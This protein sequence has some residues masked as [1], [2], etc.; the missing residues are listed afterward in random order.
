[1]E[2]SLS[3]RKSIVP[4]LLMQGVSVWCGVVNMFLEVDNFQEKAETDSKEG[5]SYRH[6]RTLHVLINS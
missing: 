4:F 5:I 2:P 6:F 1:M 3:C